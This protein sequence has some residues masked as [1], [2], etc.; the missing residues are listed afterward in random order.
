MR[1][2]PNRGMGKLK[3][4]HELYWLFNESDAALGM[5]SNVGGQLDMLRIGTVVDHSYTEQLP[6]LGAARLSRRLIVK[7]WRL[8]GVHQKTLCDWYTQRRLEL[9]EIE[10]AAAHKAWYELGDDAIGKRR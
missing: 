8:P 1:P 7:L 2:F 6:N 10:V 9:P 3:F 4:C 5:K